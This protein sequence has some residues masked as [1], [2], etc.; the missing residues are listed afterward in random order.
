MIKNP[1]PYN[2]SFL[3]SSLQGNRPLELTFSD[4][5]DTNI[6]NT[7]TSFIY[8]ANNA[9]LKSSQQLNV[10]WSKFENH[11]FFMPAT[12][13]VN[14]AFDQIINKFPFDGTRAETE[15]FFEKLTGFERWVFDNF[16]KFHGQLM[17]SGTVNNETSPTSGSYI[18]VKD[19]AG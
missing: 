6:K 8:D 11:T 19:Y 14:L 1:S 5:K 10:D 7:N 18:V 4:I 3:R 16:P 15:S 9:P 2:P 13:K 12:T 17:F